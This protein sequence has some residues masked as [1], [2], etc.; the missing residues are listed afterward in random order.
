MISKFLEAFNLS[1]LSRWMIPPA[2]GW[3]SKGR[4][5]LISA[6]IY[7]PFHGLL[8]CLSFMLLSSSFYWFF[9]ESSALVISFQMI[10]AISAI[11]LTIQLLQHVQ[12]NLIIPLTHV[13]HWAMRMRGGN[14]IAK[15]PTPKTKNEFYELTQDINSLSDMLK[16][17]TQDMREQ[18]RIQSFRTAQK[19][20]SLSILYDVAKSINQSKDLETLL[21]HFMFT[22]KNLT[23]ARGASVRILTADNQLRLIA[24]SGLSK[25]A[26]EAENCISIDT[27]ICGE[28]AKQ[29]LI[30]SQPIKLCEKLIKTNIF[31]DDSLSTI[32]VPMMY[33]G[34]C[35]GI[36]NFYVSESELTEREELNGLLTSI[37]QNLGV[38]IAKHNLETQAKR[39][40]LMEERTFLSHELH[41]SLAQTLVSLK[42]QTQLLYDSYKNSEFDSFEKE[43]TNLDQG[44]N[45]AN[46]DLRDL[47]DHFRISM[48]ERGLIPALADLSQ[49]LQSDSSITSYFQ[50]ESNGNNM[51]PNYEVQVLHIVQEALS[52]IRKHSKARNVRIMI[53]EKNKNWKVIVEDD[54]IGMQEQ[55]NKSRPGENIGLSIM[56]ERASHIHGNL[57]IESEPDEGTRIE[58]N[59]LIDNQSP[60]YNIIDISN[61]RTVTPQ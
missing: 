25:E 29:G 12:Q 8:A 35:L 2:K 40:A 44:L 18:V 38:A 27:C 33:R 16:N 60:M 1:S 17:L 13:R 7:W 26:I 51:P 57:T 55:T 19:S 52:N 56:Q 3:Y 48:D 32:A 10:L 20:N 50:D 9:P 14:L 54:G 59:F 47:L 21:S 53:Q 46:D 36:Y 5:S 23:H 45:K 6:G 24:Q 31:D 43:L 28:S 41:D 49:N 22:L 58:L 42:F 39:V 34:K 15:I 61:L 30:K 11:L 4:D 37:G